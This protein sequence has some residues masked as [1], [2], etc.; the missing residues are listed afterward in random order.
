MCTRR[1]RTDV[2]TLVQMNQL[3]SIAYYIFMVIIKIMR[4]VKL[5]GVALNIIERNVKS[6]NEIIQ[7]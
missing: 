2:R 7:A 5:R 1:I 3:N 6:G 4:C